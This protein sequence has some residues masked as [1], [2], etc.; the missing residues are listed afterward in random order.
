M[1]LA[2][3][4]YHLKSVGLDNAQAMMALKTASD[5]AAVGGSNLE[6]TTNAIAAAWRSGISG[7]QNFGQAAATVNAIIGAGNMRMQ[8]FVAAMGTGIL[9][10]ANTF[11]RLAEAG[12]RR[13]GA[14]DRR[15]CP[16]PAGRDPA[17]G[18]PCRCSAPRPPPRRSSSR[19]SACP[20]PQLGAGDARSGGLIC[21]IGLLRQ[22]IE[23]AGLGRGAGRRSCSPMRSA[24][25]SPSSAILTMINN[26]DTLKKKQDQI[27]AGMSKYGAD[28][29]AQ[30]Q[31]IQAQLDILRSTLETTGV[32]MGQALLPP[33]HRSW[34]SS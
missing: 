15:R 31:T 2:E 1:Q 33:V 8:D 20:P 17:C 29:A 6:E 18:C 22:H 13:D 24:A 32:R 16:R 11:G 28:V 21:A 34:S 25:A 26:Y 3:A 14:D 12:R 27:N 19:R 9:S 4:L 7:A 23:D 10:A 30:R 5:L